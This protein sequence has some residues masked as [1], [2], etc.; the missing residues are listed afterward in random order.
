MANEPGAGGHVV[1]P[2]THPLPQWPLPRG[3][4]SSSKGS[5]HAHGIVHVH[6]HVHVN[7]HDHGNDHDH[8]HDHVHDNDNGPDPTGHES[9]SRRRGES[10]GSGQVQIGGSAHIDAT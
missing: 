9:H 1:T 3:S 5:D 8:D 4:I 7:G 6:V 2:P 10:C